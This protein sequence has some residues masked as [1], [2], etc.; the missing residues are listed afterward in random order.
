[1]HLVFILLIG[2]GPAPCILSHRWRIFAT[3]LPLSVATSESCL[4]IGESYAGSSVYDIWYFIN[5]L[6]LL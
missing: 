5:N 2:R 6:G 3:A 4:C 1:M